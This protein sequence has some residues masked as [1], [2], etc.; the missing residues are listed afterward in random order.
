MSTVT[1]FAEK[2]KVEEILGRTISDSIY[3]QLS[4]DWRAFAKDPEI[5]RD[6]VVLDLINHWVNEQEKMSMF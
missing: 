5:F 2:D 4:I 1:K 3:E 6:S